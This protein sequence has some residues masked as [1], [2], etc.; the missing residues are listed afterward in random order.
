MKTLLINVKKRP[1]KHE[2]I[3]KLCIDAA[4]RSTCLRAKVGCIIVSQE[5]ELLT[6]GYNGA[7]PKMPECIEAGCELDDDGSCI[8]TIHAEQNAI[9]QAAKRG[10]SIRDAI[11]YCTVSPC[12]TCAKMMVS[13]KVKGIYYGV[14]YHKSSRSFNLFKRAK[15]FC[16]NWVS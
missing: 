3:K 2:Y 10:I 9:L 11:C 5:Y 6:T 15:I 4:D 7:P 12:Y 16:R 13:L 14:K 1:T 8:R